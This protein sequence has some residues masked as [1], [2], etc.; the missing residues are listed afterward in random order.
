M[1]NLIGLGAGASAAAC[2]V[3]LG[4]AFWPPMDKAPTRPMPRSSSR[5][6]SSTL[7]R[8]SRHPAARRAPLPPRPRPGPIGRSRQARG[9][10]EDRAIDDRR[11]PWGDLIDGAFRTFA[12]SERGRATALRPGPDRA[13][14]R[15]Y[16]WSAALS[17]PGRRGRRR[18]R[19]WRSARVMI[20]RRWR[21]WARSASRATRRPRAPTT[22]GRWPP[23]WAR[24]GNAW[25][26]ST[27]PDDARRRSTAPVVIE[28]PA[29]ARREAG[30]SSRR[31]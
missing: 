26:R 30:R 6:S 19:P 1:P 20:R 11:S 7:P 12:A 9:R 3:A 8:Q 27:R 28:P 29:R 10:A 17:R 21:K 2:A 15:R 5:S 16:R 31:C 25:R 13:G 18:A 4:I 24:R 22:P 23:A 14:G